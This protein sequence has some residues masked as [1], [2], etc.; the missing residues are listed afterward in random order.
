MPGRGGPA[1]AG[2]AAA[3]C[4]GVRRGRGCSPAAA[5]EP[6]QQPTWS[7]CFR[8]GRRFRSCSPHR[9][10]DQVRILEGGKVMRP[11]SVSRTKLPKLGAARSG[12]G[13]ARPSHR[14]RS[15]GNR[16]AAGRWA[17]QWTGAP[18]AQARGTATPRTSPR[19]ACAQHGEVLIIMK[20]PSC[21]AA[22]STCH[23]AAVQ[24][25]RRVTKLQ[26]SFVDVSPSCS[27][28]SY[29]WLRPRGARAHGGRGRRRGVGG[30]GARRGG[31][32][33]REGEQRDVDAAVAAAVAVAVAVGGG[34]GG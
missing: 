24:L 8:T 20:F 5:D 26:C 27:A 2:C 16:A 18:D 10:G 6:R 25:C 12:R 30:S 31:G 29:I 9:C 17:S 15:R 28:A 23:Q 32:C 22:L 14:L 19:A 11:L 13:R 33:R 21:S 1:K 3:M 4:A 34:G 7:S